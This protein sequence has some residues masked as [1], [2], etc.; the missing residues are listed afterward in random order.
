MNSPVDSFGDLA[1]RLRAAAADA[2]VEFT[3]YPS[4]SAMLD[5]RRQGRLFV[6]AF[7]PAQGFG[8]DEV[9]DGEGIQN[10][11]QFVFNEFQPAAEKLWELATTGA[12]APGRNPNGDSRVALSLLVVYASDLAA[13]KRFYEALGLRFVREQHGGPEHYAAQ[14]GPATFEIFP[15]LAGDVSRGRLRI[16][17][18]VPSVEESV[19]LA[20][21]HG[22]KLV[23][24]AHDS[25]WGRRAVVQDPDGN[26]IEVFAQQR[27]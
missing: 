9:R 1:E 18:H 3:S 16:G 17:F 15:R 26:M 23:T 5:V 11:Y 25:P 21:Q 13:S 14:A 19:E 12:K 22:A 7:S 10:A 20:V 2:D 6:M 24:E 27:S 4:G 8:V